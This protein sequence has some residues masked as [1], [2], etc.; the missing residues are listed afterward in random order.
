MVP[1]A[2]ATQTTG[3][4]ADVGVGLADMH[5]GWAVRVAPAQAAA[6]A[7]STA[8][9]ACCTPS[10]GTRFVSSAYARPADTRPPCT[11]GACAGGNYAL[12]PAKHSPPREASCQGRA[13]LPAP[14]LGNPPAHSLQATP[15]QAAH[16]A[17]R[18]V[19]GVQATRSPRFAAELSPCGRRCHAV[20]GATVHPPMVAIS[21]TPTSSD[22]S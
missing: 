14:Q 10:G 8:S 18:R 1:H 19:A 7:R 6:G 13:R 20:L 2:T 17:S 9:F 4:P 21:P 15:I 5:A 22:A 11:D 16:A 12:G 3:P